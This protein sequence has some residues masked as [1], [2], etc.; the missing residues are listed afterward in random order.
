MPGATGFFTLAVADRRSNCLTTH[1]SALRR[2]F[3]SARH[4]RPFSIEAIVVLPEHL[5]ALLALPIGETDFPLRWRHIRTLFTQSLIEAG[6]TLGPRDGTGRTL[7]QRRYWDHMIRDDN[8]FA[9]HAD[10]MHYNPA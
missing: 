6:A 9:L 4:E 8:D 10:Y 3:R 7:W 2:A 1:I 5:H